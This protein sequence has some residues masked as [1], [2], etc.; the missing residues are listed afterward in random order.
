MAAVCVD[1]LYMHYA[2]ED[3]TV[4]IG[5]VQSYIQELA[6]LLAEMGVSVRICQFAKR[7][8]SLQIAERIRVEGFAIPEGKPAARYQKLHNEAFRTRGEGFA[9]TLFA[10]DNIIPKH[11]HGRCMAIQHGIGWDIPRNSSGRPLLRQFLARCRGSLQIIRR[12]RSVD[13]V[14]CVDY[15]FLNWYRTQVDVPENRLSVISNYARIS[16]RT[17][18][19]EGTVNIIFARRLFD[20]RGTR[21]F[22][23]AVKPLLNSHGNLRVTVA[24]TGPDENWMKEQLA[25]YE[26]VNFT[27]YEASQTAQMHRDQ[28]IAVV[29]TIGSEG[30]SLSLLEA[31]AAGCAV[32]CSDVGGMTQIVTDGYNGRMVPAG[33][34]EALRSAIDELICDA[35]RRKTLAENGY[36]TVKCAYSYE[37]WRAQWKKVLDDM[38]KQSMG[39][40][41][42]E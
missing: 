1:M 22:T 32:V 39:D 16:P 35:E 15:N 29:P 27:R 41:C 20:Y 4:S 36:R 26:S 14:V 5:G 37:R 9:F 33:D 31:M 40:P 30:T 28:H 38:M 3:G 7:P 24:G 23:E 17:E 21:V 19:P 18:K 13:Q 8:F 6:A 2:G 10:T 42:E 11:L 34:V 12:I 25:G